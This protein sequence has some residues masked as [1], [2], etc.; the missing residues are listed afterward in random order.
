MISN[1]WLSKASVN[2]IGQRVVICTVFASLDGLYGFD[3]PVIVHLE[4][5]LN[6]HFLA[7]ANE[8]LGNEY[9]LDQD[10]PKC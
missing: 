3:A 1:G 4:G 2:R 7:G 6:Y 10:R 9:L 8:R 5:V